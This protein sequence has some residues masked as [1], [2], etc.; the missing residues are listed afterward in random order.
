MKHYISNT[1]LVILIAA[2]ASC[3][4]T[5]EKTCT[6]DKQKESSCQVQ[7]ALLPR[8]VII[9][10]EF[11]LNNDNH[12]EW[13]EGLA[14]DELVRLMFE[15]A[16]Q[17]ELQVAQPDYY[18]YQSE[19]KEKISPGEIAMAMGVEKDSMGKVM[20]KLGE[21]NQLMFVESWVFDQ[22]NFHLYKYPKGLHPVR[23]FYKEEG[24]EYVNRLVFKVC[25]QDTIPFDELEL[26]AQDVKYEFGLY[27][28]DFYSFNLDSEEWRKRFEIWYF[29]KNDGRI[30]F[31][32]QKFVD[33]ILEEVMNGNVQAYSP[34]D[35]T[36]KLSIDEIEVAFDATEEVM[37]VTDP[38]TEKKVTRTIKKQINPQEI[39][40]VIFTED[41]YIDRYR[42][43]LRKKVK[44]ITLVRHYFDNNMKEMNSKEVL[45][46]KMQ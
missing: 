44:S 26:F 39:N 4:Q 2:F 46:V 6:H 19:I 15:K 28:E 40:T 23:E 34:Q 30:N 27:N 1:I 41:W 20:K 45:M 7:N 18:G 8:D 24:N 9:K 31:N 13:L 14:S 38:E 21:V 33:I 36:K 10:H 16:I 17:G 42:M 22:K 29:R 11:D 37:Q 32:G 43:Y 3:S 35:P 5:A 25:Y 12:P